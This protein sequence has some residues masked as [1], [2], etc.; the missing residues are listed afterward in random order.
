LRGMRICLPSAT[1]GPTRARRPF[2]RMLWR[3][4]PD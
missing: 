3:N 1:Q 2:R 4:F